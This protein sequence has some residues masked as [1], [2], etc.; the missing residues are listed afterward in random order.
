MS[1]SLWLIPFFP[2]AG[3]LINGLFGRKFSEKLVGT[4]GTA[5]I[6]AS[7]L[8]AVFCFIELLGMSPED[9][10]MIN[11]VYT[12]MATG[13]FSVDIAFRFD[14]LS[15][16]MVLVVTG[17]GSLIHLYSIGYMH[18]DRGFFRYFAFLN[19]FTFA[20]LLLVLGDNFLVLFLGWE[21]VGLCSYLLIGFW[22]EKPEYA[23]AGMKAF[24]VNRIGDFGFLLGMF[25]IFGYYGSLQ[26]DAVFSQAGSAP[27]WAITAICLLLFVGATGKSAQ[28]PLYTWLPDA[29]AGPTPVSALIHAATMVTAGVYMICRSSALYVL[30]PFALDVIAVIGVATALLAATIALTS[31]DIKKVL[32]YSTVSQLGY[33]FLAAGV[34][35]FATAT[36]HLMTHAF[37][38]ALMFLGA[39]S[40]MHAL[41]NETNIEKMGGLKDKIGITH[42]TFMCGGLAIAGIFPLAGFWSKDEIL[43]KAFAESWILWL[44]GSIVAGLTAF[45]MFRMIFLV[46]Y[47]KSRVDNDVAIHIHESPKVMTIPLIIL[48]FLSVVGGFINIPHY[49]PTFEHFLDPVITKYTNI[50]SAHHYPFS[51]EV[52]FMGISLVIA[53]IGIFLAYKFYLKDPA[54]SDRIR[55]RFKAIYTLLSNRYYV[56]EIYNA[57]FVKPFVK[58]SDL[59]FHRFVDVIIIDGF[60]NTSGKL[61]HALAGGF[62]RMHTGVVQVYAL[63]IILGVVVFLGYLIFG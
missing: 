52:A 17:V 42:K 26:F 23:N 63:S 62:R 36:F 27:Q 31:N 25:M 51:L 3:F 5:A 13:N 47:G 15:A 10:L 35:A 40:V 7:F 58:V 24:V 30:S 12:W 43:W 53:S 32:A 2:L 18:G 44:V 20:M 56:D 9:R 57:V 14:A 33:M 54:A 28:I 6:F 21:G 49:A 48:A 61:M 22:Y 45:Y 39:G 50:E 11:T 29:M 19:L 60:V 38:K 8:T 16:V 37:F 34:G 1:D 4:I 59:F 46:F 41:A 55:D